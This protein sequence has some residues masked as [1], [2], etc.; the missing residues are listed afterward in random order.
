M[1][2]YNSPDLDQITIGLYDRNA[3]PSLPH[4][5]LGT[6]TAYIEGDLGSVR[7]ANLNLTQM[8]FIPLDAKSLRFATVPIPR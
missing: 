6:Y 1:V 2:T 8:G 7:Y 5:V 3:T 4:P